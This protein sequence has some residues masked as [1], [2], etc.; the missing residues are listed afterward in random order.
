[1][2][3]MTSRERL[4]AALNREPVD[5]VPV[6]PRIW[7][8]RAWRGLGDLE[9]ADRFGYDPY[10]AG[11]GI[12]TPLTNVFCEKIAFSH[13]VEVNVE[14]RQD[15]PKTLV[16][17][18]FRTPGGTLHDALIMAEARGAYGF[19]PNPEWT[20]PLVKSRQDARLL[21]YLL[22]GPEHRSLDALRAVEQQWGERGLVFTRTCAGTDQIA[23]DALGIANAMVYLYDDEELFDEVFRVVDE[24]NVSM[25]KDALEGGC[26]YFFDSTFNMSLSAGWSPATWRAKVLPLVKRHVGLVHSYGGKLVLY[27]D[28]KIMG[29]MDMVVEAGVDGLQTVA[30]PPIGDA[31]FVA[32]RSD[33]VGKLCFWGGVDLSLILRG[34]PQQVEAQAREVIETLGP[35]GLI[36]G[37][38]DS[39]RDGSP[40][41]NVRTFCEAG[42]RY[43]GRES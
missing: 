23:I 39:I 40:E 29:I 12:G 27:D 21:A 4:I 42:R 14:K 10:T 13:D 30:P 33:Y 11:G 9:C 6:S 7:A 16:E 2:A 43:G 34:T 15:G 1:M 5:A 36:L 20:E 18:T 37:T 26:K 22:P 8:Y 35:T 41:E 17:R 31:D 32:L 28:G 38:S 19:A 25:F 24:W 3:Q